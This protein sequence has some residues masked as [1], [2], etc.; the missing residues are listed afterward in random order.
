[1]QV[2]FGTDSETGWNSRAGLSGPLL[3]A[4]GGR[5]PAPP[6][7]K[8]G[9]RSA[10]CERVRGDEADGRRATESPSRLAREAR[11]AFSGGEPAWSYP[12]THDLRVGRMKPL[13]TAVEV[14]ISADPQIA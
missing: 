13:E 1:M 9:P 4:R 2:P 10:T 6:V 5:V 7:L 3:A 11:G 12:I 8:H 14:R